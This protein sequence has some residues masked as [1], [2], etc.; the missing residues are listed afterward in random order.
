M[1]AWHGFRARLSPSSSSRC[2]RTTAAPGVIDPHKMTTAGRAPPTGRVS[3][4][5]GT[6][7]SVLERGGTS[8]DAVEEGA[9]T[10]MET[11]RSFK[12][13]GRA[14]GHDGEAELD[15]DIHDGSGPRA[16]AVANVRHVKKPHGCAP[17]HGQEPHVL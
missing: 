9:R 8:L 13:P 10:Q 16:G 1:S 2:D 6:R 7:V 3:L 14:A 12:R 17:G 15:A 4:G 5:R 11:T